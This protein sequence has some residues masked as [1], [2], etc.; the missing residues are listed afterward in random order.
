ML[1]L[2]IETSCDETA[3]SVVK[4]GHEI[5]S[6]II[7]SQAEIHEKYGGVFPELACRSHIDMII[8]VIDNALKKAAVTPNQIDLIA[9]AKGPGL[10]GAL[11]IGLNTAKG[12]AL[13]WKKPFIGINHIEAHLYASM[14]NQVNFD[15]LV[16][17]ALGIVLSGGHTVFLE[18]R[19]IGQYQPI[20]STIDDAIGEAFDK[21]ASIL[22]MPYPGGPNIEKLAK[23]GNPKK[24]NI[25]PAKAPNK[26]DFSFS[27]LKTKILYTVKGQKA[28]KSSPS[29]LPS[30]EK[31]HIAAGF[32]KAAF[33]DVIEKAAQAVQEYGLKAV[34]LGGGVTNNQKLREMFQKKG[35]SVPIFWP[36]LGLS[37]DNAAMIA[38]MG[39][40]KFFKNN[41]SDPWDLKAHP[42]IA[43]S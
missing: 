34:Y 22:D 36:E 40:Q 33:Q 21:V 10:I 37:L 35:L 39:Y 8:P 7:A 11:L 5:L 43:I 16:F 27:G 31:K 42:R 17:P 14:M 3:A 23:N 26:Y 28:C 38:G 32:Q 29:I 12:L 15:K 18:I 30:E 1:V 2:G 6:N 4:D 41:L 20:G 24:Y 25:N 19:D 9:V 13:S